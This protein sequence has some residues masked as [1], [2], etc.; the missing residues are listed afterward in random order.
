[1]REALLGAQS[2]GQLYWFL[3]M[4]AN[5]LAGVWCLVFPENGSEKLVKSQVECF[6]SLNSVMRRLY[7]L[8]AL[9]DSD[10]RIV[11]FCR[12]SWRGFWFCKVQDIHM[13]NCFESTTMR[14]KLSC[15][16]TSH[17]TKNSTSQKVLPTV[18]TL[19]WAFEIVIRCL[20]RSFRIPYVILNVRLLIVIMVKVYLLTSTNSFLKLLLGVFLQ[21]V[22]HNLIMESHSNCSTQWVTHS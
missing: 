3:R 19:W 13:N 15:A 18:E 4:G 22:W 10:L 1:M 17:N 21:G 20:A 12:Y 14:L 9:I 7:N 5:K 8:W 11:L 16:P 2:P 6:Q